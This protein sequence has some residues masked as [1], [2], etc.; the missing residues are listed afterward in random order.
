MLSFS[1]RD[2]VRWGKSRG[3]R[4]GETCVRMART[5]GGSQGM[6]A[7]R[8][9]RKLLRAAVRTVALLQQLLQP[10]KILMQEEGLLRAALRA[11][12][13]AVAPLQPRKIL[14]REEWTR[15]GHGRSVVGRAQVCSPCPLLLIKRALHRP[16]KRTRAGHGRSVLVLGGAQV[17]E[18]CPQL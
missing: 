9:R 15:A 8:G 7:R 16:G 11:V 18:E 12:A 4:A 13:A 17:F 6:V 10:R 14:V 2:G 3:E 5:C 1:N